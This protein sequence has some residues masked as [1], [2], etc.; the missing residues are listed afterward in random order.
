VVELLEHTID[1]RIE[2]HMELDAESATVLGEPAQ[3]ENALLNLGVNARDAMPQGG[4][5]VYRTSTVHFEKPRTFVDML[6]LAPGDYV[7]IEVVDN[8]HGIP[9]EN[10]DRV[11]EPFFTTKE[12]GKGTGLGLAAVYGT[13]KAHGGA[14]SADSTPGKGATFRIWLPLAGRPEPRKA[15]SVRELPEAGRGVVLLVDDEES[16]REVTARMIEGMGC[17]VL[18][19]PDGRAGLDLFREHAGEIDLVVLDLMMPRMSGQEMLSHIRKIEPDIP[20]IVISAH[21][22]AETSPEVWSA[23]VEAVIRKPFDMGELAERVRAVLDARV[24][25]D[26]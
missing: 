9:P 13:V 6:T 15:P 1:R 3:L 19:A 8:G 23:E 22:V 2:V 18:E 20:V 10:L 7:L 14:V 24:R 17:R 16:V 26:G 5:L 12:E 21:D 25:Q 4:R 11:F